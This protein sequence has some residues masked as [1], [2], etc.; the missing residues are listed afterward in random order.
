MEFPQKFLVSLSGEAPVPITPGSQNDPVAASAI[1][2]VISAV[3]G[4]RTDPRSM[5]N[6]PGCIYNQGSLA[7]RRAR[8]VE[9]IRRIDAMHLQPASAS[10]S[11]TFVS[12]SRIMSGDIL[13]SGAARHVEPDKSR[14]SEIKSCPP[15][16]LMGIHGP[17]CR[18]CR[19]GSVGG[20]RHVLFAPTA[21]ASIRSVS[22]L[23][24]SQRRNVLFSSAGAF[25]CPAV[26]PSNDAIK[27][28]SRQEDGL[29]HILPGTVPPPAVR[30]FL[31]VAS[32]IK[33][34]RVHQLHRTLGHASPAR[35]RSAY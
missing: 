25:L 27:I 8:F 24:D 9:S 6:H 23:V 13:D 19:H 12:S 11:A 29:F 4:L 31:S 28:A 18:I 20:F 14:F 21:T 3:R 33:R 34:E 5:C 17:S 15:V 32:Q 7:Q 2:A 16:T 1:G 30:A 35:M 22:T 10:A 26:P